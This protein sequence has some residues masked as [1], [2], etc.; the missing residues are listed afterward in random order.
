MRS[1]AIPVLL[2]LLFLTDPL[3]GQTRPGD[4]SPHM[5]TRVAERPNGF[6]IPAVRVRGTPPT[7]DGFLDEEV[8]GNAPQA[9][10]F[11]QMDPDEGESATEK[12]DVRVLC[13]TDALFVAFR[14]MD[15]RPDSIAGQLTRRD[16]DSYSDAVHIIIDS[17]FDRR[18]AFHFGVNPM[19]VKKDIYRFDD[20][21]EDPTWDAVWDVATQIDED[22]WTAEF[23]IPYSQLRFGNQEDQTW[24]INFA[25][26]IARRNET[27][28]WAPI[29]RSDAAIV[30]KSGEL[31]GLRGLGSPARIEA[32]P[33]S[34][35]RLTRAPG[36]T[37]NPFYHPN[38]FLSSAG[39]DLKFGVTNDLTLD[40]TINPDFG[41]VEADPAQVNLTASETFYPEQRPFFLEGAGIFNYGM[42]VGGGDLGSETLFYS[43]RIGRTPQGAVSDE[44]GYSERPNFTTILGAW[45]LSGKTQSGWSVG[46]LHSMTAEERIQVVTREGMKLESAVEPASNYAVARV[47]RDFR[48]GRSAVGFIGT[49]TNR[50]KEA[51]E[52]L[53]LRSAAYTGGFD[54]RHRFGEED[55]YQIDAFVLGSHV[56][57]SQEAITRTQE[58]S[59]R[60]F[61]RIDASHTDYDPLRTSLTGW[62]AK[63]DFVKRGGNFWNWGSL[64]SAK[65]PGFEIND[66]GFQREVDLIL[67]VLF[68]GYNHY[69]PTE[70][71]RSWNVSSSGWH[72]WSFGGERLATGISA[73]GALTFLNYWGATAGISYDAEAFSD[74]ALRGGPLMR[75]EAR[76]N[77]SFG[78][79]SDSR[80]KV[81]LTGRFDWGRATESGSGSSAVSLNLRWRPSGQTSVGLGPFF[82]KSTN[83]LQ[84]VERVRTPED[85]YVF[86]RIEQETVG[87]TSRLDFTFTPDLTLQLYAQPFVSAGQYTD[88]KEVVEPGAS[89]YMDR[90]KGLE[91]SQEDGRYWVDLD[92]EGGAESFRNPDFNVQQF[93]S[94]LV[95]RWEYRPGSLLYLVWSQGRNNSTDQGNLAFRNDLGDLFRQNAENVFM[96]K[97][98]YWITP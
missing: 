60:Y 70:N 31:Q 43:R 65:S 1:L 51:A 80:K 75:R 37:E 84:W 49:T 93:R 29:R 6:I 82:A 24:G 2:T 56:Q 19:G 39:M 23:R 88:F 15:S 25:R 18:T 30:S 12:T 78:A 17:Y 57:G 81:Q 40:M 50:N 8:W 68:A 34:L 83:D 53:A 9:G 87:L 66:L 22:G 10:N 58:Y 26:E 76:T 72:G 59:S 62:A 77:G 95:L 11:V 94:T 98:S 46:L 14:A 47:Q 69:S 96:L 38:D 42:G 35:A 4:P 79:F 32:R 20:T 21:Q 3:S 90:V 45:K 63:F 16:Q 33:F 36:D 48:E 86:G 97:V 91:T 85:H 41:Q 67:H 74:G 71:L 89:R 52:D 5:E 44:G 64:A 73:N 54:L 61:Q 92:G 13:G 27:S 55:K 28:S 7:I